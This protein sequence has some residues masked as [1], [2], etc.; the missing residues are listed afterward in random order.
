MEK[1]FIVRVK[2][3]ELIVNAY[4]H[5]FL[6]NLNISTARAGNV[7]GGGD[8]AENRLIPDI[9]R[10]I[11]FKKTLDIRNPTFTRPWQHVLDPIMGYLI[12]AQ[13]CGIIK[14]IQHL[15]LDQKVKKI[16]CKRYCINSKKNISRIKFKFRKNYNGPNE[17]RALQLNASKAKKILSFYPTFSFEQSIDRTFNWYYKFYKGNNAHDLCMDD[18]NYYFKSLKK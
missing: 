14:L 2:P 5:S 3:C 7:I 11:K 17:A 9:I 10:S 8:W 12:L 1:I 16:L 18:I 15:I 4:N 6:N 13:K